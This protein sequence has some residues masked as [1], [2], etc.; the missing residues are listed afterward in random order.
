M[1]C[2]Y[3]TRQ[4]EHVFDNSDIHL[5]ESCGNAFKAGFERGRVYEWT[6]RRE[7]TRNKRNKRG[8]E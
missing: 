4:A 5:C 7:L 2:T 6:Y 8:K 1:R 3:C